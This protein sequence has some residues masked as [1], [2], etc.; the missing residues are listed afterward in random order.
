MI[1]A[2]VGFA[3]VFALAVLRVPLAFAMGGV[4]VVGSC[5]YM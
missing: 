1:A 5:I 2:L 4:C 3:L